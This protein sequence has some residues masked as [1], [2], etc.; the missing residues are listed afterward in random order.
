MEFFIW[1]LYYVNRKYLDYM[2]Y[3]MMLL[4]QFDNI[5]EKDLATVKRVDKVQIP[6]GL[7][8]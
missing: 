5:L 7:V 3:Y 4:E 8:M 6:A 1:T 2:Q